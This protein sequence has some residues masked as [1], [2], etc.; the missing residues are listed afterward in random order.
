MIKIITG[1]TSRSFLGKRFQL[2]KFCNDDYDVNEKS[3]R[4][5]AEIFPYGSCICII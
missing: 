4:F 5:F 3:I 2:I 1:I